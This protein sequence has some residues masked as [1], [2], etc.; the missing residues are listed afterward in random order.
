MCQACSQSFYKLPSYN[1]Q[2]RLVRHIP[3][4]LGE[5][6]KAQRYWRPTCLSPLGLRPLGFKYKAP[7]NPNMA[8]LKVSTMP[9]SLLFW[10][11]YSAWWLRKR[12]IRIMSFNIFS[13]SMMGTPA[14]INSRL[15]LRHWFTKHTQER[16]PTILGLPFKLFFISTCIHL[17][18]VCSPEWGAEVWVRGRGTRGGHSPY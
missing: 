18:F 14:S 17:T 13:L 6:I 5:E 10:K 9:L 1:C 4:L 7:S 16:L 2:H 3:L 15:I 8:T 12:I 11:F